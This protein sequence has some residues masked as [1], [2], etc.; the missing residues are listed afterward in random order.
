L[1]RCFAAGMRKDFIL[2]EEEKQR[3]KQRLEENRRQTSLRLSISDSTNSSSSSWTTPFETK[4][5]SLSPTPEEI[6]RV[7]FSINTVRSFILKF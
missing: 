7:S 6:D 1:E 5:E 2:S 4:S 3:R